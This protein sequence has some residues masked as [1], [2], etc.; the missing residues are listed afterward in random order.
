MNSTLFFEDEASLYGKPGLARPKS[1]GSYRQH[2]V[3]LTDRAA[4]EGSVSFENSPLVLNLCPGKGCGGCTR[5]SQPSCFTLV[6][7]FDLSWWDLFFFS[8]K[9]FIV[10][11]ILHMY[12]M[13]CNQVCFALSSF[14]SPYLSPPVPPNFMCSLIFFPTKCT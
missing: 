10:L 7:V 5:M 3:G 9:M 12:I 11:R 8:L 14:Q 13:W 1:S 2:C 6:L 4:R